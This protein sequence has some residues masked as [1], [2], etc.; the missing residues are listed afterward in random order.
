ME[1]KK[2]TDTKKV[3]KETY[4]KRLEHLVDILIPIYIE[5]AKLY[6]D[7]KRF[8]RTTKLTEELSKEYHKIFPKPKQE[9]DDMTINRTY[10]Y[11]PDDKT[12]QE[13][14]KAYWGRQVKLMGTMDSGNSNMP[15]LCDSVNMKDCKYYVC[16][17]EPYSNRK[18]FFYTRKHC[19]K[20][21]S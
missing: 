4:I 12:K 21:L 8:K 14:V 13:Y 17:S 10:I 11:A 19:L 3:K 2:V 1:I 16:F 5:I 20:K 7:V 15:N 18:A 6:P 9:N